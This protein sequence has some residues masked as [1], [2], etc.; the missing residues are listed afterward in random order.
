MASSTAI[1]RPSTP[2]TGAGV[3]DQVA[4]A[5][6]EVGVAVDLGRSVVERRG[7]D[8]VG[9]AGVLAP[10]GALDQQQAL[11]DRREL[12]AAA[13]LHHHAVGVGD[14]GAGKSR[15]AARRG[16]AIEDRVAD[17]AQQLDGADVRRAASSPQQ[18][19][20]PRPLGRC[21][22]G[23]GRDQHRISSGASAAGPAGVEGVPRG[24]RARRRG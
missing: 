7:P 13:G 14:Q 11:G 8:R 6:A 9:A 24:R 23:G 17:R 3:A 4:I 5:A 16:R 20:R 2:R 19:L 22:Q 1:G 18:A 15:S 12:T 21:A 10:A